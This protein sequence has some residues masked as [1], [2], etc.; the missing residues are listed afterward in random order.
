MTDLITT[1]HIRAG[2]ECDCATCRAVRLVEQMR[3]ARAA[4]SDQSPNCLVCQV[5]GAA[6]AS[7]LSGLERFLERIADSDDP[8]QAAQDCDGELD[9]MVTMTSLD[10][11]TFEQIVGAAHSMI[12]RPR[13]RR[14]LLRRP[15][16]HTQSN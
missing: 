3:I 4:L 1:D 7:R 11:E 9:V 16:A 13:P 6:V 14:R 15:V 12:T 5:V 8:T 2:E 10:M